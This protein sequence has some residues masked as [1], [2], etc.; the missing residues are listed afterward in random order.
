MVGRFSLLK[1]PI[2]GH[3]FLTFCKFRVIMKNYINVWCL[4]YSQLQPKAL[5]NLNELGFNDIIFQQSKRKYEIDAATYYGKSAAV[6]DLLSFLE[7]R[8]KFNA[9]ESDL[10][11]RWQ[12]KNRAPILAPL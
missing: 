1:I 11:G 3:S 10:I 7:H 5:M 8:K 6:E 12:R 9:T 2:E 4:D